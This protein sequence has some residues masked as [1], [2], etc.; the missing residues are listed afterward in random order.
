[1]KNVPMGTIER[2]VFAG[3]CLERSKKWIAKARESKASGQCDLA[4]SCIEWARSE[5]RDYLWWLAQ[6]KATPAARSVSGA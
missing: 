4:K 1:M 2:A 5:M 6:A 3:R